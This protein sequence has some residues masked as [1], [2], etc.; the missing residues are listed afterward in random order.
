MIVTTSTD[1]TIKFF[2]P[3]S[4]SYDLTDASNNPHAQMRPGHYL[5]L[6]KEKTRSNITFKEVK[7]I[8]TS[9]DTSCFAIRNLHIQGI[10][11]NAQ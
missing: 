8:Y 9:N 11:A 5:P 1:Q 2:D 4:K 7:R 10:V 6:L 3:I